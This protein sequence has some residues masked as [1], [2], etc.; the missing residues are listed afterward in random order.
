[1][2]TEDIQT[3]CNCGV[4][5]SSVIAKKENQDGTEATWYKF[6][7]SK[8]PVCRSKNDRQ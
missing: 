2:E 1:M 5:Y 7:F 6:D 4:L 8:C 3:C